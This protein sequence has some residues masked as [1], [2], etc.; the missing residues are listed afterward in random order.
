[1]FLAY[2]IPLYNLALRLQVHVS[3]PTRITISTRSLLSIAHIISKRVPLVPKRVFNEPLTKHRVTEAVR[4]KQNSGVVQK[5]AADDTGKHPHIVEKLCENNEC[6][7]K[8]C[9][10]L[11]DPLKE[12]KTRGFLTHGPVTGKFSRF[13]ADNDANGKP[14]N[15][16]FTENHDKSKKANAQETQSY[17]KSKELKHDS[18]VTAYFKNYEN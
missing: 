13:L 14:G 10:V 1:M 12:T 7:T 6:E 3:L 8:K 15:Q 9:P 11:C 5:L 17:E 2:S 4:F 18:K 16:Y